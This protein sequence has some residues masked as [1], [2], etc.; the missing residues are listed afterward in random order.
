MIKLKLIY[1]SRHMHLSEWLSITHKVIFTRDNRF[2]RSPTIVE[3][4]YRHRYLSQFFKGW[5]SLQQFTSLSEGLRCGP[6]VWLSDRF[7]EVSGRVPGARQSSG[8]LAMPFFSCDAPYAHG[9]G[10]WRLVSL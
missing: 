6:V 8:S 10:P 2:L 3:I 9:S 1:Y 7:S 5:W 4:S